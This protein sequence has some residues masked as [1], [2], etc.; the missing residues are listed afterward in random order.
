MLL[1]GAAD[2]EPLE[3]VAIHVAD[4]L[5]RTQRLL[6]VAQF[7]KLLA[8]FAAEV[9][10]QAVGIDGASGDLLEI[11]A[12]LHGDRLAAHTRAALDVEF[13]LGAE[14]AL[15]VA[16]G[17]QLD[18]ALVVA[19][20]HFEG[21]HLDLLH[22][23]AL[24]GIHRVEAIDHVVLVGVGGGVAQGAERVHGSERL[25]ATAFQ[26]AV[27]A[28]RLVHD[29]DRPSGLDQVDGL[30]TAGLLAVLVEV[31]DVLLVDRADRHHHDLD[32]WAGG[33]VAHLAELAGVVEEELEGRV[34][35]EGAEVLFGDLE[36]LVNAFLDRHGRDHDDELG[37]AV[38]TVQLEDRAQVNVGLARAGLHFHGEIARGQRGRRSQTVADLDVVEVGQE[39][40]IQQLQ[41]VADAQVVLRKGQG[42]L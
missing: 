20:F 26:A 22:Q 15:L 32:V 10:H 1:D 29:Q 35:V 37:E 14:G 9:L 42:L 5:A 13:D 3:G 28:L 33:E 21:G 12:R 4:S 36:R 2:H 16:G 27:H 30:L 23:L 7:E 38:A 17:E 41:A 8:G 31:V 25:L 34:G 19:A 39:F 11:V 18:V 24:V 6:Q 40:V